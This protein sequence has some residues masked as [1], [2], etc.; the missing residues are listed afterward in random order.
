MSR[1]TNEFDPEATRRLFLTVI[2]QAI[3]D[4][5]ENEGEAEAAERWLASIDFDCF[6]ESFGCDTRLFQKRLTETLR[7]FAGQVVGGSGRWVN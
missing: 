1:Q 6:L 2:H 7:G 4:V 5:L 3:T